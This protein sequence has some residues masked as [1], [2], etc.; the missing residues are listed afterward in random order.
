MAAYS[1]DLRDRVLKGIER[2][3]SLVSIAGRLEVSLRWVNY[4]KQRYT[5]EGERCSRPVGGYRRSRL[6][7]Q[8]KVLRLWI[9]EKPDITLS[10]MRMRL[11]ETGV[12]IGISALWY[13]LKKWGLTFKKNSARKRARARGRAAGAAQ[14]A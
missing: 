1:Q 7:E 13:Q 14:L 11:M 10:E 2:G 5:Q 12:V 9:K 4:V 3:E 6:A 8:E